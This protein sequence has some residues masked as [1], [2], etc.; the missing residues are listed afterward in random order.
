MSGYHCRMVWNNH[1]KYHNKLNQN[2]YYFY[3]N[4]IERTTSLFCKLSNFTMTIRGK[5]VRKIGESLES[6][7]VDG[8]PSRIR[9]RSGPQ[10]WVASIAEG[11]REDEGM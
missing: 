1:P 9:H 8:W 7:S 4:L 3:Y 5:E 11:T 6:R 2:A 10:E